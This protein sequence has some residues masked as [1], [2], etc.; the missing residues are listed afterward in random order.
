MSLVYRRISKIPNYIRA[1]G[2]SKGLRLLLQVERHLPAH[3][4]KLHSYRI[5]WTRHPIWLRDTV[6]DHSTFWQ[7]LVAQ[8]YDIGRFPHTARLIE[9]YETVVATGKRP[10]IIDCG[11]NVGLSAIWFA[12]KFPKAQI[13][14][15]EPEERNFEILRKN[16]TP[17]GDIIRPVRGAVWARPDQLA[18]KNPDAG[19]AAFQVHAPSGGDKGTVRAYTVRELLEMSGGREALIVKLDIEGAQKTLFEQDT[20]WV[21]S[22]HLIVLELDDWHYPWTGSSRSFFKC[23]SQ[24]PYEY[25]LN[26]ELIFCFRDFAPQS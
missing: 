12:L 17:Y 1:F 4:D 16:V 22:T 15:V 7:C 2:V 3:S 25:L 24:Y 20:E 21:G 10:V 23:L 6:S 19:A 8:N 18:I 26:G 5:P 11:G 13:L 9:T 14:V